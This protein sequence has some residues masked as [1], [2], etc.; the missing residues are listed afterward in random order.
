L[1]GGVKGLQHRRTRGPPRFGCLPL[2]GGSRVVFDFRSVHRFL[3]ARARLN[4]AGIST[5]CHPIEFSIH[6]RTHTPRI[7]LSFWNGSNGSSALRAAEAGA[8]GLEPPTYGFGDR[9]STN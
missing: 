7:G 8:E 2:I 5:Q 4:S 1:N 6:R 9:R 3:L